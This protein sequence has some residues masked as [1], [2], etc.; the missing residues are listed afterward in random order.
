MILSGQE[1]L[2]NMIFVDMYSLIF[3]DISSVFPRSQFTRRVD[4]ISV[5]SNRTLGMNFD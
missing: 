5:I 2:R 3:V 1:S 4:E